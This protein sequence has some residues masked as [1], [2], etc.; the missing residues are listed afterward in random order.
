MFRVD[1]FGGEHKKAYFETEE[2][3]RKYAVKKSEQGKIT[4]ILVEVTSDFY[5]VVEQI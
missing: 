2:E 1:T 5:E 4:F 3:A